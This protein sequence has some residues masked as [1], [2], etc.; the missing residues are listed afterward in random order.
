MGS[1][2]KVMEAAA[3]TKDPFSEMGFPPMDIKTIRVG[4][5]IDGNI[6]TNATPEEMEHINPILKN[7]FNN[8]FKE[9]IKEQSLERLSD[10]KL[11]EEL[12]SAIKEENFER[13]E[14][15][16]KEQEKRKKL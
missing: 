11:E 1:L 7:L 5:D 4:Q 12:N 6:S 13:A 15:I 16:R 14:L 8:A 10:S 2:S 3:K 9:T